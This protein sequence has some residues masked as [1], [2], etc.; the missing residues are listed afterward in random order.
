[1]KGLTREELA[2][3]NDAVSGRSVLLLTVITLV[4]IIAVIFSMFF[5]AKK[6]P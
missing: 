6:S 4:P 1:M 3:S 5:F 2:L